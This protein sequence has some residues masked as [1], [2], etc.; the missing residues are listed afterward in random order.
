MNYLNKIYS[1]DLIIGEKVSFTYERVLITKYNSETGIPYDE[2]VQ[3]KIPIYAK[4]SAII[5][6]WRFRTNDSIKLSRW[7]S[8]DENNKPKP[9]I[10]SCTPSE[11]L[12]FHEGSSLY[13]P[14][15]GL[16]IW[17]PDQKLELSKLVDIVNKYK[18]ATN[19]E[20]QLWRLD[21]KKDDDR[22]YSTMD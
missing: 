13:N 14:I 15:Y 3:I 21:Y 18:V 16:K 12:W 20:P 9:W 8:V 1:A 11:V 10:A 7:I 17:M 19:R 4:D 22:C 2:K 5:P 6:G